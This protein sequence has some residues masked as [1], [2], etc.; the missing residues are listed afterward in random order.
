M[1]GRGLQHQL[2]RALAGDEAELNRLVG[3]LAPVVQ[4]RV[5]RC[6]LRWR[7]GPA[8]GRSVRQEVEDLTQEVF[9]QLFA[10]QGRV[11]RS[12]QPER[13]LTLPNFVGLVAERQTTSVLRSGRRSPWKEDPTLPERL[14]APAEDGGPERVAASR[15]ELR[16]LL[17]RLTEELS[18]LGRN[19][20]DL[21][22][23]Q[24]L[25]LTEVA[26]RTGLS[27]DAVYAWRSRLRR[28]ARRL[29][30]ELAMSESGGK[31]ENPS[32]TT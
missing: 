20:F 19:L 27:N 23:L 21:L 13:G 16:L 10:D 8:A 17:Q 28:L 7:I 9:L 14:D 11:L 32:W 31:R 2:R 26:R 18:P 6:L 25:S 22:F 1:D 24:E 4:A 15:E 30:T 29:Q 3:A 12:W 5:A